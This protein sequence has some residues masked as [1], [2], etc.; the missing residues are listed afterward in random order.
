VLNAHP[1]LSTIILFPDTHQVY[2]NQLDAKKFE[3][4]V[5]H[6]MHEAVIIANSHTPA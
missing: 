4:H 1:T 3:I 2:L 5:C 6:S